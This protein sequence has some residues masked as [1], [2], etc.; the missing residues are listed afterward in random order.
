MSAGTLFYTA[1]LASRT[2]ITRLTWILFAIV[3][4]SVTQ[5][6]GFGSGTLSVDD[7]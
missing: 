6:C 2:V 5:H 3:G 1:P 4:T 7:D